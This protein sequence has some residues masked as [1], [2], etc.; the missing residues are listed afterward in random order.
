MGKKKTHFLIRHLPILVFL[1]ALLLL[2]GKPLFSVET[3]HS[4]DSAPF[5]TQNYTDLLWDSFSGTWK[6]SVLGKEHVRV[7]HPTR[8]LAFLFPPLVHHTL[9]YLLNTLL[10]FFAT[11][12]YLRVRGFTGFAIYL[13]ALGFTF[14]GYLFTLIAPGHLFIFDLMPNDRDAYKFRRRRRGESLLPC[15]WR[16]RRRGRGLLRVQ[17]YRGPPLSP[18]QLS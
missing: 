6:S 5:Y 12:W 11:S 4:Y 2:F 9:I 7:F 15:P 10:L 18:V 3:L 13:P 16:L 17:R 14:S 1:L 8:L